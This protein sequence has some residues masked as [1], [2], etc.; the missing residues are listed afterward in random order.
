M[1]W[2]IRIGLLLLGF[3]FTAPLI[4]EPSTPQAWS[5]TVL[6][7]L[8]FISLWE[9]ARVYYERRSFGEMNVRNRPVFAFILHIL[10][11]LS[12]LAIAVTHLVV[13]EYKIALYGLFIVLFIPGAFKERPF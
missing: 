3:L 13:H 5:I 7:D 8:G 6:C 9:M 1:I 4:F 10:I 2:L 12:G 11:G